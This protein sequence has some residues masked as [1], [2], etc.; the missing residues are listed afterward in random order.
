MKRIMLALTIPVV[1]ACALLAGGA[2]TPN[3]A[4]AQQQEKLPG[5]EKEVVANGLNLPWDLDFFPNG[6]ALVTERDTGKLLRVKPSGET[7][8]IQ[9]LPVNSEGEGGLLGVELSPNFA[10][11][12][13]AFVY[14]STKRDN[15]VARLKL[16]EQHKP[17]VTGIPVNSNHNG[18]RLDFGPTGGLFIATGDAGNKNS[19]QNKRSQAGKILRVQYDGSPPANN[20]F[21]NR[22]WSLGHRNVQGLAWDE[23]NRLYASELGE[24]RFDEVNRIVRGENYG[25]PKVEGRGGEPRYKDPLTVFDPDNA[26]PSGIAIQKNTQRPEAVRGWDG[27]LF[28]AA[29]R[30]ERL[31]RLQLGESG[32][33]FDRHV[34]LK[35]EFGRLRHVEQAPDGSLWVL[36]SNS[37]G[38]DRIVRLSARKG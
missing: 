31:W 13:I 11:N 35:G 16:G 9:R 3:E 24:A 19:S 10:N 25:W 38:N 6:D 21:G 33:V 14:Y 2:T 32:N 30:G 18:G 4:L 8:T 20:P 26:S 36:T 29:L 22:V 23:K 1:G 34:L 15:R 7:S 28:M 27:D 37:D 12:R 5:F 17:I